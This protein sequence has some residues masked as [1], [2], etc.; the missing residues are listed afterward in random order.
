MRRG[1]RVRRRRHARDRALIKA[2]IGLRATDDEERDGLDITVH[3]ERGYH[4]DIAPA[5]EGNA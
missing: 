1:H 4:L 5:H 3:G 2:T